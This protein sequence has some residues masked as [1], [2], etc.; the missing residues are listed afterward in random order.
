MKNKLYDKWKK[1]KFNDMCENISIRIDNPKE[2]K[3]D[4]YVGLQHLDSL[5]PRILR[6]G[7]PQD[8]SKTKLKFQT[9][10]ILFGRRNWYLR[11]LAVAEREGICSAHMIVLRTKIEHIEKGFLPI[12]MFGDEFYE[13]ALSVSAGS[14]SPTIKWKDITHLEFLIPTKIEQKSIINLISEINNT[15]DKTRQLLEYFKIYKNS[16]TNELLISG[17]DHSSFKKVELLFGQTLEI[18]KTWTWTTIGKECRLKAGATPSRRHPEYFTGDILWVTSGELDYNI[19]KN[20]NEKITKEAMMKTNLEIHPPGIFMIAIAG[21]EAAGTRGRCA[22]LGKDA[23]INQSCLA[24]HPKSKILSEFLLYFYQ[25]YSEKIIFSLA[26]GTKQQSLN[27]NLVDSIQIALPPLVEQKRIVEILSNVEE[28]ITKLDKHV[29]YLKVLRKSI[30]N[31][32]L[33]PTKME[34][35]IIV[36]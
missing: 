19:I 5:E 31:F 6:H 29:T 23:T 12:F 1:I 9:G 15:I 11:R 34:K 17:I 22:I 30:L 26:Q 25:L 14:M 18:P 10:D 20:T 13:K 36:Q 3:T 32:K 33:K 7:S 35:K 4:Y 28:Q 16:K 27:K 24:F 8:V 21:L 2:S